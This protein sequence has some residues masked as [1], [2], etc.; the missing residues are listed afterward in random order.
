MRLPALLVSLSILGVAVPAPGGDGTPK[1]KDKSKPVR[2][3]LE[4]AYAGLEAAIEKNDAEAILAFRHPDFGAIDFEGRTFSAEDMRNRTYQMVSLIQPPIDAGFELGT[5]ELNGA[6]E[7]VVTVRQSF[8]RMQTVA[9]KLRKLDTSVT[10]DETWVRTAEGWRLRFVQ[11]V[12]DMKWFVDGKRVEPGKPYDPDAP[13]YA[14][15]P[16]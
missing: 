7:A 4:Q 16:E 12:H 11:N 8:S 1:L 14:P 10:Q 15:A 5:I 13:A 9:G 3:Q 6:D 2:H